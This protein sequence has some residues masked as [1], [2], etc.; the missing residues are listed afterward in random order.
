MNGLSAGQEAKHHL[1]LAQVGAEFA[2]H[3]ALGLRAALQCQY[4]RICSQLKGVNAL[5]LE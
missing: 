3:A 4:F 2:T 1:Q 5:K